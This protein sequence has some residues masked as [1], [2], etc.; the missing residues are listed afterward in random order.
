MALAPLNLI[1]EDK[2][3]LAKMANTL[4]FLCADMVQRANS[5]HPGAPMG[6]ADIATILSLYLKLDPA[7]PSWLNRDRVIFSGGHA[8]ALVYSLLHVWGFEIS[9]ED[10]M[11]FR[12]LD[13]KTPGHP[14]YKHTPGV[15]ITT[16]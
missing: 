11:Q 10:L 5:G 7:N 8:S 4:R 1:D 2:L 16:G 12:Q 9:K 13:S 6:L 15:E 14:E 3:Q